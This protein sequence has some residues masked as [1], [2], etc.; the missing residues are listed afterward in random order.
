MKR[1]EFLVLAASAAVAHARVAQGADVFPSKPIR[2]IVPFAPGGGADSVARL[3]SDAL[4]QQLGQPVVIENKG[5]AGGAIGTMEVVRAVPDGHTLVMATQ[6]ITA[7]NPA[8]NPKSPYDP[9]TDLTAIIDVAASPSVLAVRAGFPAKNYQEF[10]AEV[11][12]HPGDYTYA[13]SGVGGII[14]LMMEYFCQLTGT[15][16]RHIPFNG[17]GPAK[18][19]VIAGQVDMVYDTP[20][21]VLP[22]IKTGKLVPIAVSAPNRWKD[23]PDTPTFREVGVDRMTKMSNFGLLGPKGMSRETVLKI[24][25]ATRKAVEEPAVRKRV[26]DSGAVIVA[27]TPEE[28]AAGIKALLADLKVVVAERKLTME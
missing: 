17:A 3:I 16:I 28:Y 6:S 11:R 9:T 4:S 22:F 10:L 20:N 25:A 19:A 7:A 27:S 1:R 21:S 12:A 14:H 26:E 13:S 18:N 8:I 24:N 2:L 15:S 23:L 5:G